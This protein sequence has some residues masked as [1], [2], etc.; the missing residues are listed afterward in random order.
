MLQFLLLFSV[1]SI[2]I[3]Y[4]IGKIFFTYFKTNQTVSDVVKTNKNKVIISNI[5]GYKQENDE[6]NNEIEGIKE[7]EEEAESTVVEEDVEE[8]AEAE[9]TVVEEDEEEAESEATVVEEDE[10]TVVEENVDVDVNEVVESGEGEHTW[11]D[12]LG[13]LLDDNEEEEATVVE[14]NVDNVDEVVTVVEEEKPDDMSV[15][16]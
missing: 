12:N 7:E 15:V 8:E 2:V 10:A 9:A 14:E 6:S 5:D 11:L 3:V 1:I 4:R 13:G 16:D